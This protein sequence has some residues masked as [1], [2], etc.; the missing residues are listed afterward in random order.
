MAKDGY[1]E[2][3]RI[4]L[5]GKHFNWVA[6]DIEDF[7]EEEE[8]LLLYNKA[9]SKSLTPENLTGTDPIVS[10]IARHEGTD[11]FDHGRPAD[12]LLREREVSLS[13]LSE[14]T[15]NRFETL[16][17]RINTTLGKEQAQLGL[18]KRFPEQ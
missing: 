2:Q 16:F 11:R 18:A 14:Q 9:F 7:F 1:L 15:L 8:Y 4:I 10:R 17:E 6:A 5:V 12:V 13:K 3:Q